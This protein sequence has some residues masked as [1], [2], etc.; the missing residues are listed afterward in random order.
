MCNGQKNLQ[1]VAVQVGARH[2]GVQQAQQFVVFP[3]KFRRQ[4]EAFGVVFGPIVRNA[5]VRGGHGRQG[6]AV[7]VTGLRLVENPIR[8]SPDRF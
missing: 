4:L 8:I 3:Q 6:Q 5:E 2:V 1:I 7:I